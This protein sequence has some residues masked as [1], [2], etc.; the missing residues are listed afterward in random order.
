MITYE[1]KTNK[2]GYAQYI[3]Y[4]EEEGSM[5]LGTMKL[6]EMIILMNNSTITKDVPEEL[7]DLVNTKITTPEGEIMYVCVIN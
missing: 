6:G 1:L 4:Y 5:S 3:R 7:R 2:Y